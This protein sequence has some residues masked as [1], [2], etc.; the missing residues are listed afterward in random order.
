M[1][2]EKLIETIEMRITRQ[3]GEKN[4]IILRQCIPIDQERFINLVNAKSIYRD[5]KL[6]DLA[7]EQARLRI[8][9][10]V[11]LESVTRIVKSNRQ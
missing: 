6:I 10:T 8:L 9:S 11:R 4:V 2:E 3:E 1:K 5:Q 7:E